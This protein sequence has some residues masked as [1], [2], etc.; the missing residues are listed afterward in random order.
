MEELTHLQTSYRSH[1]TRIFNKAEETIAKDADEFSVT[2]LRTAA[3]Q[4]QKKKELIQRIDMQIAELIETPDT[5]ETA[6]YEAEELKNSILDKINELYRNTLSYRPENWLVQPHQAMTVEQIQIQSKTIL[7][8]HQKMLF[9][10]NYQGNLTGLQTLPHYPKHVLMK[11]HH[12][13]LLVST[14]RVH[15]T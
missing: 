5:L 14:L 2:Y 13:H 11:V 6:I 12:S 3:D 1:V 8:T 7:L 10:T 4:L 15:Y 9:A